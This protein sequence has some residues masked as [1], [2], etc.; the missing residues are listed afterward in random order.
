VTAVITV[1]DVMKARPNGLLT[2]PVLTPGSRRLRERGR[3]LLRSLAT[4][5]A[6]GRRSVI[7]AAT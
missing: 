7:P 4:S 5:T 6:E 2:S 1:A 3:S